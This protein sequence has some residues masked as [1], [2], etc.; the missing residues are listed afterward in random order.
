MP[1]IP[2]VPQASKDILK[3]IASEIEKRISEKLAGTISKLEQQT[4]SKRKGVT[5]GARPQPCVKRGRHR[6][7]SPTSSSDDNAGEQKARHTSKKTRLSRSPSLELFQP[8]TLNKSNPKRKGERKHFPT[9]PVSSDLSSHSSSDSDSW[10]GPA[11]KSQ[12]SKHQSSHRMKPNLP[13]LPAPQLEKIKRRE[14][15]DL[16]TLTSAHMFDPL[17][18][19]EPSYQLN[20]SS[21]SALS[22]QPT[23]AKAKITNLSQWMEAWNNFLLATLHFHQGAPNELFCKIAVIQWVFSW[24][25]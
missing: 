1:A 7:S 2:D 14:Y 10:D 12:S 25:N 9:S 18:S 8:Q 5:R 19:I 3:S 21:K 6:S 16:N 17:S 24:K 13:L 4:K 11:G 15:I 23:A 22:I 20:L